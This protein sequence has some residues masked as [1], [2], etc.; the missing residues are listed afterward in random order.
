MINDAN[1]I[2]RETKYV[3]PIG[4][5][6]S[7]FHRVKRGELVQSIGMFFIPVQKA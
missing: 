1:S 3:E 7:T 6:K 5:L 4:R 2:K